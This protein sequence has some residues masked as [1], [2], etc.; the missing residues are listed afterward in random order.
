MKT[1]M[2]TGLVL[3]VD[4]AGILAYAAT[5]PDD[6]RVS[7]SITINSPCEKIFR[8]NNEL[9]TMNRWSPFVKRDPGMESKTAAR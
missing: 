2:L 4:V 8:L 7:R 9:K 5:L 1:V 3:I 6:F